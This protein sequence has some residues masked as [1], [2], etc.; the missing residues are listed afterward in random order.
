LDV[1]VG[2]GGIWTNTFLA[3]GDFGMGE[4]DGMKKSVLTCYA[5]G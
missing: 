4:Q 3:N 5:D 2:L 1:G